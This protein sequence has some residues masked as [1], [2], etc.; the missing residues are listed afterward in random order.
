MIPPLGYGSWPGPVI[1]REGGSPGLPVPEGLH[2]TMCG[3]TQ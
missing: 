1:S 3:S 2:L